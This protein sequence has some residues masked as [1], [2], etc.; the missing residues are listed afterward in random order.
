VQELLEVPAFAWSG[1]CFGERRKKE[2][3]RRAI[4]RAT[5]TYKGHTRGYVEV[6][7]DDGADMGMQ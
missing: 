2:S 4:R 7:M 3:E 6:L 5:K 1:E